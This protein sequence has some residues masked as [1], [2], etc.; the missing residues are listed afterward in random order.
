MLLTRAPN[1]EV[2]S[3]LR[4][5]SEHGAAGDLSLFWPHVPALRE[6]EISGNPEHLGALDLPLLTRLTRRGAE[7][8]NREARDWRSAKLPRLERL[9]WACQGGEPH[10]DDHALLVSHLKR[11][12]LRHLALRHLTLTERLVQA[13]LESPALVTLQT[14]DLGDCLVEDDEVADLLCDS[15]H[16]LRHLVGLSTPFRLPDDDDLGDADEEGDEF[17]QGEPV[18]EGW[19]NLVDEACPET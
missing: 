1:L 16:E 18:L 19:K 4:L 7:V 9:D 3:A 10:D 12:T 11:T 17:R 15:E 2:L 6:L 14:L 8:S 13:L 5:R